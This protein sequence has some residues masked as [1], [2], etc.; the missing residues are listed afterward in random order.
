MRVEY[1]NPKGVKR[2]EQLP[3]RFAE[4][5]AEPC[6]WDLGGV[7]NGQGLDRGSEFL[8]LF[9]LLLCDGEGF[10]TA[11]NKHSGMYRSYTALHVT[12]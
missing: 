9:P 4:G 2:Q 6:G 3:D 1:P 8:K 11:S 10:A 12:G 7:I 5:M